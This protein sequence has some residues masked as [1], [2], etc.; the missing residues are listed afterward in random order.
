M[1]SRR[2]PQRTKLISFAF[3]PEKGKSYE[4]VINYETQWNGTL[5]PNIVSEQKIFKTAT[6]TE[7][8]RSISERGRGGGRNRR[9]EMVILRWLRNRFTQRR[10][11]RAEYRGYCVRIIVTWYA[12]CRWF[13]FYVRSS[14][15]ICLTLTGSARS[16]S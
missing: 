2:L 6:A 13:S 5:S 3:F 8:F 11:R 16:I 7:L 4:N 14:F 10:A 9:N 12:R 1:L 15:N